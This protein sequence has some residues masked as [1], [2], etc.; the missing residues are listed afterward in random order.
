MQATDLVSLFES[1]V[2][3]WMRDLTADAANH[4]RTPAWLKWVLRRPL[5]IIL[6]TQLCVAVY[7]FREA[8]PFF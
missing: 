7:V 1:T 3:S 5:H 2:V 4:A 6:L 8:L